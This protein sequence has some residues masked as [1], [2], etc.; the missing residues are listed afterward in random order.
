MS[1]AFKRKFQSKKYHMF[2]E[3]LHTLN[4]VRPFF[5]MFF[6]HQVTIYEGEQDWVL[7]FLQR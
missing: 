4:N 1:V 5:V 3:V 2:F 6:I 7:S